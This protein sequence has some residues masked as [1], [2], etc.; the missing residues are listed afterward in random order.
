MKIVMAISNARDPNAGTATV[1]MN[2][3]S[4]FETRG[5]DCTLL[6]NEDVSPLFNGALKQFLF[7]VF[8]PFIPRVMHCDI[9]D[10]NPGDGIFVF[11]LRKLRLRSTPV[12][13]ARS[14]GLEHIIHESNLAEAQAGKRALSWKYA[15]YHGGLR[16]W[17]VKQYLK[18]ADL[19]LFLNAYDRNYAIEKFGVPSDTAEIVDNGISDAFLSR[20]V[21]FQPPTE[22]KIALVGSFL[23][24]K[25]IDYSVPALNNLLR[26]DLTLSA[27]FFGTGLPPA[28]VQK[29]FDQDI[30]GRVHVV[31]HYQNETLPDLLADF[32]IILFASLTEG[33]GLAAMEGMACGLAAVITRIP[34]IADRLQDGVN[35][36]IIPPRDQGAIEAAIRR[37]IEDPILLMNLR[38]AGHQ[39]AQGYSWQPVAERN[40]QLYEKAIERNAGKR[41]G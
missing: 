8:L 22:I 32:H 14:H 5:H 29:R 16:L 24:R 31:P 6:F 12:L 18:H 19:A 27:T 39:L 17:Q 41:K 25:G 3:K 28:D 33:F 20:S 2:L 10:I 7:S 9:V 15:L 23:P 4:W 13:V 1:L 30:A 11:L 26:R 37:L 34:G 40:L 38:R 21:N 36:L 35:A